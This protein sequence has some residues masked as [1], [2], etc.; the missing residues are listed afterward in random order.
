[1]A[2]EFGEAQISEELEFQEISQVV[3]NSFEGRRPLE[4]P[5]YL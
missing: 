3:F 2:D 4:W 5:L 1:M